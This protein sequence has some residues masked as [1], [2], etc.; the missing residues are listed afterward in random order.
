VEL[1]FCFYRFAGEHFCQS[2]RSKLLMT[3]S[4]VEVWYKLLLEIFAA[5]PGTA[6]RSSSDPLMERQ[7][8][9]SNCIEHY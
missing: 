4:V 9:I 6:V 3:G 7:T 1:Y 2:G 8:D 5:I